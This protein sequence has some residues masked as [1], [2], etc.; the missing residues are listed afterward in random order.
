MRAN[1]RPAVEAAVMKLHQ[2]LH[3]QRLQELAVDIQGPSA[4]AWA[5]DTDGGDVTRGFLRAQANTIEGGTSNVLRNLI[6]E[7]VLGLPREPGPSS[8]T[9]WSQLL[10]NG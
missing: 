10:R 2:G 4:L 9:P 5:P 3:N 1:R 7:K 8:D 6:G